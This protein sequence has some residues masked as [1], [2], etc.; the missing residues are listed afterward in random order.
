MG[1]QGWENARG[2][3]RLGISEERIESRREGCQEKHRKPTKIMKPVHMNVYGIEKEGVGGG[4]PL[5]RQM[6]KGGVNACQPNHGWEVTIA[7]EDVGRGPARRCGAG[8]LRPIPGLK[9]PLDSCLAQPSK[10]GLGR[11][12]ELQTQ[13]LCGVGKKHPEPFGRTRLHT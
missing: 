4:E 10:I 2:E 12:P 13:R 5:S 11:A 9:L 1:I 7:L 3:G 6:S 8:A